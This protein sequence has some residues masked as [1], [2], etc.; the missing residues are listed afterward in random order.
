QTLK[1]IEEME[2]VRA[3]LLKQSEDKKSATAALA[4]E[5]K[6]YQLE[7][8]LHDVNQTGARMDI[9]RNPPQVLERLSAISKQS[10]VYS[11][12]Y[13]PTD[14]DKEAYS[15]NQQRLSDVEKAYL[16]LKQNADW[17]KMKVN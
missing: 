12:D 11:T 3:R 16:L 15:I 17:K 5:E 6:I 1:L 7:A 8:R 9:F 13:A 4:L 14:Q 10:V 2:S